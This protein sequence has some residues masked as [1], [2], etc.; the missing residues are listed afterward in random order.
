MHGGAAGL[1][2]GTVPVDNT[3]RGPVVLLIDW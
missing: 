2:F 1:I 3:S